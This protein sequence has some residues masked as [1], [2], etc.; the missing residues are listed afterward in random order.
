MR[1]V[2]T[3]GKKPSSSI[4]Y[5]MRDRLARKSEVAGCV[6]VSDELAATAIREAC[7]GNFAFVNLIIQKV[8]SQDVTREEAMLQIES[9]Y[10]TVKR[11]VTDPA[12]L[13]K[14]A[15]DLAKHQ[16]RI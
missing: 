10:N 3:S 16:E 1:D 2:R 4:V 9:F 11:H 7:K 6:N 15:T 12:V 13:A 14:I 8:E 5:W